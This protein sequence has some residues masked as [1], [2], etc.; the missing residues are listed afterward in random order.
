[1]RNLL[2]LAASTMIFGSSA[3]AYLYYRTSKNMKEYQEILEAGTLKDASR[4]SN[5]SYGISW[6]FQADD[7]VMSKIDSSDYLFMKFECEECITVGEFM[8]CFLDGMLRL[9]E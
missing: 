4:L 3:Y 7:I 5:E 9:D 1:M 6:G 2:H 8:K